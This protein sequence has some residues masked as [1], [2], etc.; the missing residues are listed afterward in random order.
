[1][2][3]QFAGNI[4]VQSNGGPLPIVNGGTGQSSATAALTAL[5]PAQS[6][7]NGKALV[8]N[9][10]VAA[11]QNISG[12]PG[13]SDTA[14]QYNDAGTFGGSSFLT[15]NKSTGAVTSTSTLT[16]QGLVISKAA[17]TTR[18]INFQTSGSNRWILQANATAETG[19]NAGSDF[20]LIRLADNGA[21]QN[22]VYTISRATGVMDFAVSPTVAGAPI[23]GNS[24]A[25][26]SGSIQLNNGSGSFTSGSGFTWASNALSIAT[27]NATAT[28]TGGDSSTSINGSNMVVR[29]GNSLSGTNSNGGTLFLQGGQPGSAG[30]AVSPG[31]AGDVIISGGLGGA[32]PIT[33]TN[34][35]NVSISGGLAGSNAAS[36]AGGY[37]SMTTAPR[38]NGAFGPVE[39]LRITELGE[40]QLAG[41]G[42]SS[43]Q[44][45]TSSGAGAPPTWTTLS[46]AAAAGTLTGTTLASNVVTSSLTSVG[47]LSALAVTGTTTQT[48]AVNLAGASSPL[49]LAGSAG[50]TGQ[51]L[52]SAGAGATPTWAT[53]SVSGL[54]NATTLGITAGTNTSLTS[55]AGT[56]ANTMTIAAA[57]STSGAGMSMVIQGSNGATSNAG[58]SITIASG[59]PSS[60]SASAA[61]TI[62]I[63]AD[64]GANAPGGFV[65]IRG[66]NSSANGAAQMGGSISISGGNA[67]NGS[68][69]GNA[70]NVAI[71][72]GLS[73]G[74]TSGT[75]GAIFFTT[76]VTGLTGTERFRILNNG[77]WGLSGAANIGTSGQVLTSQGAAPP[78]WSTV[79]AGAAT[80]LLGTGA[81]TFNAATLATTSGAFAGAVSSQG[82]LSFFT[83][84]ATANNR[85]SDIYA[86]AAGSTGTLHYRLGLD[87][88]SA[89][90]DYLTVTRSSTT[91]TN[92]TLTGTKSTLATPTIDLSTVTNTRVLLAN[93]VGT[94][95]TRTLFTSSTTNGYTSLGVA[96]NGTSP[97]AD[98]TTVVGNTGAS[99]TATGLLTT[100]YS[101]G[102]L[103]TDTSA[104]NSGTASVG[105]GVK[106]TSGWAGTGARLGFVW[107]TTPVTAGTLVEQ[108]RIA[109][110]G[111]VGLGTSGASGGNLP[112]S[113]VRLNIHE[114]TDAIVRVKW[115]NS[116]SGNTSTTQGFDIIMNASTGSSTPYQTQFIHRMAGAALGFFTNPVANTGTVER[117]RIG[118]AGDWLIGG[119]SA[120]TAGQLYTSG[121]AGAAPAWSSSLPN[122]TVVGITANT[123]QTITG[124]AATTT[125]SNPFTIKA[126]GTST[127][128][129][130]L[131]SILGGDSAA[132]QSGGAITISSGVSSGSAGTSGVITI[133][134]LASGA[135]STGAINILTSSSTGGT[136]Q[137][138][139]SISLT[140]GDAASAGAGAPGTISITSGAGGSAAT[141]SNGG[142][143]N[144]STGNGKIGGALSISAGNGIGSTTGTGGSISI[145]AGAATT[146][147]AGVAGGT[148]TLT[149]GTGSTS[150]TGGPGGA[151]TVSGGPGAGTA[152]AGGTLTLKGG[153]GAGTGVGGA[154][155]FQ[156]AA[157]TTPA[158]AMTI[159]KDGNVSA[160]LP[161]LAT[162]ATNG[163]PYFPTCAGTPT[164]VP[165]AITGFAP[166]VI[167]STNNKMYFYAAAGPGGPGWIALN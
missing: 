52:T 93:G 35:G 104:S 74:A 113:G 15:V 24:A 23:G 75:G 134:T 135:G 10:T 49:Q 51:V 31:Q 155:I 128:A 129:A 153:N 21:T 37:I 158:T 101:Y 92:I 39:R 106:F 54:A 70:G 62:T 42:G 79:S 19:S 89:Q 3:V 59:T 161:S 30:A 84:G 25:G 48:G 81:I 139:G 43:G 7:Q 114:P 140:T 53:N 105:P 72:G 69:S 13:G 29:G 133:S 67:T 36:G 97:L 76:A 11:W 162:T 124:M 34:G 115:S 1:M 80:T 127:G 167:D 112:Q 44:V 151:V 38:N 152:S 130:A 107:L 58:G 149:G 137:T 122:A 86:D 136:G 103:Q 56:S 166:V 117:F 126:G 87:N 109:P 131:F 110:T 138:S 102:G 159:S 111:E 132:S 4:L 116:A 148:V 121:G 150:T 66:G 73:T 157:T 71:N 33:T 16:N 50:T 118:S 83:A 165:T 90:V 160:G 143:V 65:G 164:G 100:N 6:G 2:G 27:A 119:T 9:G 41:T 32:N 85:Y 18:P 61:G 12:A 5:L 95:D 120:G 154:I 68:T 8:T 60:A 46:T 47:T 28:I 17:A 94:V 99:N 144:I 78:I 146:T 64:G 91:A 20:Q 45:F 98:M 163:F 141:G 77:A 88:M 26:T 96:G 108:M 145:T 147:L 55:V 57:T 156:T 125:N 142:A 82:F 40:W 22:T 63:H 14:I 123:A